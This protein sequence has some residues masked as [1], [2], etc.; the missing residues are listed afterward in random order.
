MVVVV[1]VVNSVSETAKRK[2]H[3]AKNQPENQECVT[4]I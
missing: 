1:V 4:H 2:G 3:G